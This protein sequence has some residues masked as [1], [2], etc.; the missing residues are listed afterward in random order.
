MTQFLDVLA[1][2]S[3]SETF[4]LVF[5]IVLA[6]LFGA[7]IGLER[8]H[9]NRPAGLRTHVLVCVGACLTMLTSEYVGKHIATTPFD[10]TRLGAQVIS[11][12]GFLGAG[13]IIR[14]GNTVKGLTTAASIWAVACV[15]LATGIGFYSGAIISTVIIFLILAYFKVLAGNAYN[16]DI[17]S[18]LFIRFPRSEET[19]NKVKF[20]LY[21]NKIIINNIKLKSDK[22]NITYASLDLSI[23]RKIDIPQIIEKIYNIENVLEVEHK[24]IEE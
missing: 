24:C 4:H 5:R 23:G 7:L 16:H 14:N 1:T 17:I 21:D 20:I 9:A 10:V 11:G 2:L 12:I 3:T 18:E 22:E 13:T 8:E 15:G 6:S 19:L